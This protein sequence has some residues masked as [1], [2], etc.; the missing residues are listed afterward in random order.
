MIPF[1]CGYVTISAEKI[2]SSPSYLRSW[3]T[4]SWILCV[5][6]L[7]MICCALPPSAVAIL[8]WSICLTR[9]VFF[10][11]RLACLSLLRRSIDGV[12]C[13]AEGVARA[14]VRSPTSVGCFSIVEGRGPNAEVSASNKFAGRSSVPRLDR[15]SASWMKL[16]SIRGDTLRNGDCMTAGASCEVSVS[17]CDGSSRMAVMP[18][19]VVSKAVISAF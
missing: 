1:I 13:V 2:D 3:A 9:R 16:V 4:I 19:I 15:V 18:A 11:S 5:I 6:C 17:G 10:F 12:T 8:T 7:V 14:G